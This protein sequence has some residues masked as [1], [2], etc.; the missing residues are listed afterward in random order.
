MLVEEAFNQEAGIFQNMVVFQR[1]GSGGQWTMDFTQEWP[2]RSQ[3]HQLSYTLPF[4]LD[5]FVMRKTALHYRYQLRAE[6]DT[7]PA[8]SPRLTLMLPTG[9][10]DGFQWGTQLNIPVSRQMGDLYG[11]ANVGVTWDRR[12]AGLSGPSGVGTVS[13][14]SPHA[15][16]SLIWRTLPMVHVLLE[17]VVRLEEVQA[18]GCCRAEYDT[19]WLVSPGFR[20]GRNLGHEQLVFGVGVPMAVVGAGGTSLLLYMSYE[21]PFR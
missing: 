19:S 14:I 7:G 13:M 3:K 10:D 11:H 21:L 6:D 16:G 12:D 18:T 20:V 5:G 4:R 1:S 15:A 8:L 17:S 9:P 2:L